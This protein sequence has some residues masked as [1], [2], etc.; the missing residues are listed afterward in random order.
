MCVCVCLWL[1]GLDPDMVQRL[2]ES[3]FAVGYS[4]L[5]E[6][7]RVFMKP[8]VPQEEREDAMCSM[9]TQ[10]EHLQVGISGQMHRSCVYLMPWTRHTKHNWPLCMPTHG[11]PFCVESRVTPYSVGPAVCVCVCA[12]AC[13]CVPH[14]PLLPK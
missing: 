13:V 6:P 9:L 1:Q 4:Q 10:L 11:F 12:C 8:S 14:R 3:S 2:K 5:S 7:V